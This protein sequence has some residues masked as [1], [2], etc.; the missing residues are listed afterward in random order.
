MKALFEAMMQDESIR[1]TAECFQK[2]HGQSLI[3]G[4]SGA[5]KHAVFAAAYERA[6]RPF[7]IFSPIT[8]F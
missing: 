6:P 3:Y 5:Q 8:S 1:R 4:V 7:V 2:E